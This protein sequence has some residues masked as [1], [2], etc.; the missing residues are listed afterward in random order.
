MA[1]WLHKMA[2]TIPHLTH[3]A[4]LCSVMLMTP[5][6]QTG[7]DVLHLHA[8]ISTNTHTPKLSFTVS[9][10][11]SRRAS[12]TSNE[13]HNY[14]DHNCN[15]KIHNW[16]V[17]GMP[18]HRDD[19]RRPGTGDVFVSGWAK[20]NEALVQNDILSLHSLHSVHSLQLWSSAP[21][22]GHLE[23]DKAQGLRF[24]LTRLRQIY[25]Y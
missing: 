1:K 11:A 15:F 24:S 10:R 13:F 2:R 23:D 8:H 25:M 9:M 19:K 12:A 22:H 20:P 4:L 16:Y 3:Y 14:N 21:S 7:L 18:G 17:S 6:Q 5:T